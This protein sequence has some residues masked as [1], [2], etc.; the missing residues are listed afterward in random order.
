MNSVSGC[1]ICQWTCTNY[2]G[3]FCPCYRP[4]LMACHTFDVRNHIILFYP[5]QCLYLHYAG[6]NSWSCRLQH[7]KCCSISGRGFQTTRKGSC[8]L[9][10]DTSDLF[11]HS[12]FDN[13]FI[14]FGFQAERT[15]RKGGMVMCASVLVIMCL[16]MLV[17]LVLKTILF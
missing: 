1:G 13:H 9:S 3:S 10:L 8:P 14:I 15:Q 12:F 7:P 4:G 5:N 11:I 2:E 16:V 6:N 17:L